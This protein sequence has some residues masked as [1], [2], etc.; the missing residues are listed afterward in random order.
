MNQPADIEFR[1]A[2]GILTL[3]N[4]II[5]NRNEHLKEVGL[6]AEQADSL[7][8]FSHNPESSTTHLKNFLRV[9]HQT[10]S[11]LVARLAAK[12][13]IEVTASDVDA[14][15]KVIHLTD[16]GNRAIHFLHEHGTHTGS[17]LLK[18]MSADEQ[19]KFVEF[20]RT[21]QEN[22]SADEP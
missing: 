8:F 18:G 11:G 20:I 4:R 10:A 3:A 5:A 14:R 16:K 13:M 6:T 12:D 9:R 21:A 15:A 2:R 22:V 19:Q 1:V 7:L 17:D